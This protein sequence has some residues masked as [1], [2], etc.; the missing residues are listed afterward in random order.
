[1]QYRYVSTVHFSK[2]N[3]KCQYLLKQNVHLQQIVIFGP[4]LT[5]RHKVKSVLFLSH[6]QCFDAVG[7]RLEDTYR[8][9]SV[10]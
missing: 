2:A 8:T 7:P 6:L 10:F 1:M 9:Y 3:K 5:C 4:K